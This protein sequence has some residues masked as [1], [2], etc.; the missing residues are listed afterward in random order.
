M[1]TVLLASLL[2]YC[3]PLCG[4]DGD[5]HILLNLVILL[6]LMMVYSKM[7]DAYL[8]VCMIKSETASQ[9]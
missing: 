7:E 8:V 9:V 3:P 4:D 5:N 2:A 1:L 6:V